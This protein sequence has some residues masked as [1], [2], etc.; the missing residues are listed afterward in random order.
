MGSGEHG[1]NDG[2]KPEVG[3][4]CH[5]YHHFDSSNLENPFQGR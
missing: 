5:S 2:N 1:F 3:F 4:A